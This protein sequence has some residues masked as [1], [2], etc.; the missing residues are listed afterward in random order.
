MLIPATKVFLNTAATDLRKSYQ[1]LSALVQERFEEN[2]LSGSMFIFYNRSH[3]RLKILYW[4]LNG[5]CL[6]Q[7]RL[8]KGRF[9]FP[10]FPKGE[11][12]IAISSYQL[13]G[14]LQGLDCWRVKEVSALNYQYV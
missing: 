4:H 10:L 3:D 14:L 13:Q 8:E 5:L 1:T 7:K 12:K 11:H 2:P 9:P 6:W